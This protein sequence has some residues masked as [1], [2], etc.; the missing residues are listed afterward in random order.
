MRPHNGP[1]PGG[2]QAQVKL[3]RVGGEDAERMKLVAADRGREG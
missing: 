3:N 1:R 2:P